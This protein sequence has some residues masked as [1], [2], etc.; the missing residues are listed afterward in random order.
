[1]QV[2]SRMSSRLS[3]YAAFEALALAIAVIG[4]DDRI[5][6]A[7]GAFAEFLGYAA[8]T[9]LVD[10][11]VLTISLPVAL[12][13]EAGVATFVKKDGSTVCGHLVV[14]MT[15]A[16]EPAPA[17]RLWIVATDRR[18]VDDDPP[19]DGEV[20]S[21]HLG[22]LASLIAHEVKNPLAGIRGA[23]DIIRDRLPAHAAEQ[24]I[25]HTITNRIGELD[26]LIDRVVRY[27]RPTKPHF[28]TLSLSSCLSHARQL[29]A[30]DPAVAGVEITVTGEPTEVRAD[31]RLLGVLLSDLLLNAAQACGEGGRVT[32]THR[33]HEGLAIVTIDDTGPGIPA[34]V[35]PRVFEPFFT[36]GARRAG[37]GL[38][39]AKQIVEAHDGRLSISNRPEGGARVTLLLRSA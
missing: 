15:T 16:A 23:A 5:V 7:N 24:E 34:E 27:A 1:M 13:P 33:T 28:Q 10:E 9:E 22:A 2:V 20:A 36:T 6:Y 21:A 14:A 18:S 37:L 25:L 26:A 38:P 39:T 31:P 30:S 11:S 29:I 12:A 3:T 32:V 4:G 19:A 35:L 17:Q 8:G